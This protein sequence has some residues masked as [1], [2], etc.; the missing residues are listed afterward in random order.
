MGYRCVAVGELYWVVAA[1]FRVAQEPTEP[2][3]LE[4]ATITS[5]G[6]VRWVRGVDLDRWG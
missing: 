1:E 3:W 5:A 6:A 2:F 4:I